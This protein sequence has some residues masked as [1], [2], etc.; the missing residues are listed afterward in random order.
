[1]LRTNVLHCGEVGDMEITINNAEIQD[2]KGVL[3]LLERLGLPRDGVTEHISDF[4][5]AK[6]AHSELVGTVG[7]EKSGTVGLLRSLGVSQDQQK[8][9]LGLRLTSA[10]LEDAPNRGITEVVLL[11]TTAETFFERNFGFEKTSRTLYEQTLHSSVE[12]SLLRCHTAVV[13]R[14]R[15]S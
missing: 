7:M 9:G 14:L 15:L 6:D 13:M 11:T 5:V 10:M 12:W 8:T 2:L 1:M 4:L 3:D